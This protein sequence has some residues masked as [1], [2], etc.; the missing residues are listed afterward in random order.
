MNAWGLTAE[1]KVVARALQQYGAYLVD[2]GGAMAFAVQLLGR[3]AGAHRAAWDTLFGPEF[4][5]NVNRIP[6]SRL[7]VIDTGA[8]T[9]F[10]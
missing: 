4:Y 2:V 5:T 1:G 9:T 3:D 8:A 6:T 7:R 10:P